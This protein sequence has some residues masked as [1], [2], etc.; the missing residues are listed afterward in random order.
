L[1]AAMVVGVCRI[2]LGLPGNDSLKGKRRVL[3]RV[4][5]RTRN[6]FNVAAAEVEDLDDLRRATLG[7]AVISNDGRHANSMIDRIASFVE[8]NAE[9]VLLSRSVELMHLGE[10][11]DSTRLLAEA[12]REEDVG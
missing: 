12:E 5:D 11:G 2:V 6:Q 1:G 9:A 10:V 3:R 8:V 7:L 4:L